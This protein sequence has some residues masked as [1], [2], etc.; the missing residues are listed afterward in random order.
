MKLLDEF[1]LALYKLDYHY[2]QNVCQNVNE[3][4]NILTVLKSGEEGN[5]SLCNIWNNFYP[6][7]FLK[8]RFLS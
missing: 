8:P 1:H 4:E 5:L 2:V 6:E 7:N 3:I